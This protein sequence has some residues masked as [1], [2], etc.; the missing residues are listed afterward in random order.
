MRSTRKGG[1]NIT[2]QQISIKFESNKRIDAGTQG[3]HDVTLLVCE[4]PESFAGIT[5]GDVDFLIDGKQKLKRHFSENKNGDIYVLQGTLYILLPR[6]YTAGTSLRVQVG[7]RTSDG[8]NKQLVWTPLSE[9]IVFG[10]SIAAGYGCTHGAGRECCH[11]CGEGKGC[12]NPQLALIRD[13]VI[14]SHGHGNMEA[15]VQIGVDG[16]GGLTIGGRSLFQ[17]VTDASDAVLASILTRL[18]AIEG[19]MTDTAAALNPYEA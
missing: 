13:L 12:E 5:C 17:L 11:S 1:D 3:N 7:G 18:D 2:P 10:R 9:T 8:E 16:D 15:L 14:D 6:C 19:A 4:L